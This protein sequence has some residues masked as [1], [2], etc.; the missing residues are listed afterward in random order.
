MKEGAASGVT[1]R[2]KHSHG[3]RDGKGQERSRFVK[4]NQGFSLGLLSLRYQRSG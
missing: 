1:V 2:P 4:G 3:Y